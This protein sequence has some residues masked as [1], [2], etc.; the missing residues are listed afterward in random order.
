MAPYIATFKGT[1]IRIPEY[2]RF[3]TVLGTLV[4][5]MRDRSRANETSSRIHIFYISSLTC[6]TKT[7]KISSESGIV[8]STLTTFASASFNKYLS[9]VSLVSWPPQSQIRNMPLNTLA[10]AALTAIG[11]SA[12]LITSPPAMGCSDFLSRPCIDGPLC[13]TLGGPE[14]TFILDCDASDTV[15]NSKPTECK[16]GQVCKYDEASGNPVCA[17]R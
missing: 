8:S 1:I 9:V 11:V 15:Y 3:G 7:I 6:R 13:C 5:E 16:A 4:D 12:T 10:M 2:I 14:N 17:S